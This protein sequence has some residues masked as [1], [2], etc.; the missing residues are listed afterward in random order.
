MNQAEEAYQGEL[1]RAYHEGK[2]A[3]PVNA[4]PWVAKIR[5]VKFAPF[6]KPEDVVFEY[7][8][9]AGW[10]LA[11]LP[12]K[13]RIGCDISEFLAP[14][15]EMH[16]VVFLTD[17]RKQPSSSCDVVL[18]H[19][20]LEHVPEPAAALQEMRRILKPGGKLLMYVPYEIERRY[21]EYDPHEPNRHLY[22]W[23]VQTLASLVRAAGFTIDVADVQRYGYDRAAAS[24]AA[25]M[26]LG[27]PGF[28]AARWAAQAMK[29]LWEV[30]VFGLRE[31]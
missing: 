25:K 4:F 14:A 26:R 24:F 18:C 11:A 8:V 19:H 30:R 2:R 20:A 10:N 15:V 13:A 5:A 3:L 17:S 1:G 16:G 31:V 12:C 9:G 27:E 22:S 28:R 7:G 21:M 6:I 29:P 23:N